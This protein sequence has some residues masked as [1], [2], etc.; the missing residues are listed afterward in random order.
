MNCTGESIVRRSEG[1]DPPSL[2]RNLGGPGVSF[3]H[4]GVV[5]SPQRVLLAPE[6]SHLEVPNYK[7]NFQY[8]TYQKDIERY[9]SFRLINKHGPRTGIEHD[10][11][12]ARF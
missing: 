12:P 7:K 9:V 3:T 10:E 1:V 8:F 2:D 11:A 4:M 6:S 5:T